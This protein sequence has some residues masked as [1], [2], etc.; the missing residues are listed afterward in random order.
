[1][2]GLIE[3]LDAIDETDTRVRAVLRRS[4]AFEPGTHVP[5]FT[6]V[7]PF[8]GESEDKWRRMVL[9]LV[10]GLW[11]AHPREDRGRPRLSIGAAAAAHAAANGAASTERRFISLL[12]ADEDQLPDRARHMLA[13]LKDQ[14]IDFESLLNGLLYWNDDRKRTQ[15][16]W[17]RDFY[18]GADATGTESSQTSPTHGVSQ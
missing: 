4:L 6:Y 15:N 18:R 12:D 8:V 7:E 13:L 5:S 10:A 2:S 3:R 14:P 1:M 11:A 9:Y 17:A 16:R